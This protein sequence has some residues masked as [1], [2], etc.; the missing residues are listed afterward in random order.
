MVN[1]KVDEKT[2]KYERLEPRAHF[3]PRGH[4]Q[5]S[6][7]PK[8]TGERQRDVRRRGVRDESCAPSSS[9]TRNLIVPRRRQKFPRL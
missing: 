1:F 5:K 7:S 6:Y 8:W 4:S 2:L 9:S 3:S